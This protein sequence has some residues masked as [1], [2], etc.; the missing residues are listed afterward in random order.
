MSVNNIAAAA[1]STWQLCCRCLVACLV[2]ANAGTPAALGHTSTS[3]SAVTPNYKGSSSSSSS[4]K[5]RVNIVHILADDWGV[6]DVGAYHTLLHNGIDRPATPNLDRMARE[7]T[8]F[9]DFHTLGA[10]CSPSRASWVTG[11][12]PSDPAVRIHLVIG[13]PVSYTHLTLPTKRIV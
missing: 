1:V 5:S 6:G 12:S 8:L 13:D 7:G 11:R 2:L 4:N 9:T 10:E 3:P